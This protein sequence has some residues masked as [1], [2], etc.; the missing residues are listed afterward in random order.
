MFVSVIVDVGVIEPL[1]VAALVNGNEIVD[2]IG[3]TW[4]IRACSHS[5]EPDHDRDHDDVLDH[6][7]VRDQV[8]YRLAT[9]VAALRYSALI[10]CV[11]FAD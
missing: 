10:G 7:Y 11:R 4:T 2:M 9:D 5:A 1:D 3:L 8:P 6:D